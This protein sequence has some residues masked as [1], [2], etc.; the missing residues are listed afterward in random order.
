MAMKWVKKWVPIVSL[1]VAP[2]AHAEGKGMETAQQV[3]AETV[4]SVIRVN[5]VQEKQILELTKEV[6]ELQA[7]ANS[8]RDRDDARAYF[9]GDVDSHPLWP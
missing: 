1:A 7:E 3:T 2:L 6:Q 5:D 8:S 4:Q 9:V